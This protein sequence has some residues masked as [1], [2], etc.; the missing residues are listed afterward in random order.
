MNSKTIRVAVV[1]LVAALALLVASPALGH[2]KRKK[3]AGGTATLTYSTTTG[4]F[5]A[6]LTAKPFCANSRAVSL[7]IYPYAGGAPNLVGS[8]TTNGSGV[9]VFAPS[10]P[11]GFQAGIYGALAPSTH[12]C[13]PIQ[14]APAPA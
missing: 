6:T 1:A 12:R 5:T 3:K 14:T 9:V 4:D 7:W 8:G 2:H 10:T 11:F 13:K